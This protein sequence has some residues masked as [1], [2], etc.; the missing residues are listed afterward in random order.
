[1]KIDNNLNCSYCYYAM[2]S[3]SAFFINKQI[4]TPPKGDS[5]HEDFFYSTLSFQMTAHY[6]IYKSSGKH[7]LIFS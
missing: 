2:V 7:Q 1:M 3:W 6:G 4:L 5:S